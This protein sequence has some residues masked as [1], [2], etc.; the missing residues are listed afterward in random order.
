MLRWYFTN[1][2]R[3]IV[4]LQLDQDGC[5]L[6]ELDSFLIKMKYFLQ[7]FWCKSMEENNVGNSNCPRMCL[8]YR[9]LIYRGL[10]LAGLLTILTAMY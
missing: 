10:A 2:R 6:N 1:I 7:N 9:H 4:D 3:V 8:M 5:A